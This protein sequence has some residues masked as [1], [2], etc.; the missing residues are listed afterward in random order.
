MGVRNGSTASAGFCFLTW[1]NE[2]L[3]CRISVRSFSC[4]AAPV[5]S[6]LC[7]RNHDGPD[8]PTKGL[9]LSL[10]ALWLSRAPCDAAWFCT[11]CCWQRPTDNIQ[12]T[13]C[14]SFVDVFVQ[15]CAAL[16]KDCCHMARHA[17]SLTACGY[18]GDMCAA[19]ARSLRFQ[20]FFAVLAASCAG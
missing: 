13:Q 12:H 6:F 9:V 2:D 19:R 5:R 4:P 16:L 18:S 1:S 14:L 11:W 20:V 15:G 3:W 7:L 10:Y 17:G 8:C